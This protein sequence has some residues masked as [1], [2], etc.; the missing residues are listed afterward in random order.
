MDDPDVAV[1]IN[2]HAADWSKGPLI[3]KRLRPAAIDGKAGRARTR[4]RSLCLRRQFQPRENG[5]SRKAH[6]RH[7][8]GSR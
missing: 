7:R 1:R 8:P 4:R 3:R 6:R 5:D 2:G